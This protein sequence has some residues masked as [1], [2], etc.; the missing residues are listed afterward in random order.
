M[1]YKVDPEH[2]RYLMEEGLD[3]K[4]AYHISAL[5]VRDPI[6]AFDSDF[7]EDADDGS[8]VAQFEGLNSTNWN[9]MRFKPPP[10]NDSSIGWRVEFRTPDIQ[11]TDFENSALTMLIVMI[12]NVINNF[13]VDFIQPVTQIDENMDKA[14]LRDALLTQ[15]FKVKTSILAHGVEGHTSNDLE[16]SNFQKSKLNPSQERAEET[17]E[18][19]YIH[20]LLEGKPSVGYYGL[21]PLFE[22]FMTLKKFPQEK[23]QEINMYLQFLL[24]RAKGEVKTDAKFIRD[25]VMNHPDY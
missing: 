22:E 10:S 18:E 15:K 2:V 23:K 25:F 19:L 20:E 8:S 14:Y 6:V 9:S 1:K 12:Q 21:Y 13:D 11:L 16:A 3:E 4:L 7:A 24:A 5:F 17:F